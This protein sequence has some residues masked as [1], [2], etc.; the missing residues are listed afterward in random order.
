MGFFMPYEYDLTLTLKATGE[1]VSL[2]GSFPADSWNSL[3]EFLEYAEDLMNTKFV[4]EGAPAALNMQWDLDSGVKVQTQLPDWDDVTVFLHKFRPIGLESESTYFYK[5]CSILGEQ[6]AHPYVRNLIEE[7]REIYSGR[8]A[9][10]SFS[11][12]R[13]DVEL[14]LDKV[15]YK[16]LNSYEYHRDKEKR[17]FIESLHDEVFSLDASKV[18]FLGLLSD[19][20]EAIYN[21]AALV[22]VVLGKDNSFEGQ[23]RLPE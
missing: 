2:K 22:R 5:I 13:N 4:K 14:N 18:I 10:K 1:T 8:R 19:K 21:I 17:K 20:T 12:Q 23:V 6:L 16:W 9:Q 3:S 11:M 7:Q 15:L